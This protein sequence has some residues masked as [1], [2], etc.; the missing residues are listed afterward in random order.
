MI[1]YFHI[2]IE[3][4]AVLTAA[5]VE[6]TSPPSNGWT[7]LKGVYQL[8]ES[9]TEGNSTVFATDFSRNNIA[10]PKSYT[11]DSVNY[12]L[13]AFVLKGDLDLH[14][15]ELKTILLSLNGV[16]AFNN[17]QEYLQFITT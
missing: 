16:Q 8:S 1:Q 13:Y 7:S 4:E 11:V 2:P 12:T 3:H 15:P 5:I 14:A 10:I 9:F 17:S 6:W